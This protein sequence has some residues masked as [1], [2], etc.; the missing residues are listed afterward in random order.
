[1]LDRYWEGAVE[2]L[3]Q[4]GRAPVL[5]VGREWQ[6]A[7]GAA[8]LAVHLL[9][10]GSAATLAT[11]LGRDK[12]GERLAQLVVD[13]G[14]D[15]HAIRC[16][17]SATTQKIRAVCNGRQLLRIDIDHPTPKETAL[18]LCELVADL[19]PSHPWVMLSD[20][21]KGSLAHCD[22]IIDRA[23]KHGCRVL[24]AP[25]GMGFDRYRGAWLLQSSESEVSAAAGT[26]ADERGFAQAMAGL[27]AGLELSHLL[28][29]RREQGMSLF[30]A[31]GQLRVPSAA[32][33]PFGT[34]SAGDAVLAALAAH[35]AAGE[36]LDDAVH[37]AIQAGDSAQDAFGAAPT[38]SAMQAAKAA[39]TP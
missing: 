37:H 18:A 7:G 10:R 29:T 6:R 30:S 21:S 28:V 22:R 25:E 20:S 38:R 14:V 34:R 9:A 3:P 5:Q 1:M 11:L 35:L 17:Q 12:A 13:A 23:R 27:R 36:T 16:P 33:E 32:Q 26:W 39:C 19:L 8:K 2:S 15:L 24:I 4:E 31:G